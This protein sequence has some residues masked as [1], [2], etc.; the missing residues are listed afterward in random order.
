M[1]AQLLFKAFL[2]ASYDYKINW[3]NLCLYQHNL[4]VVM[5]IN[6]NW[7]TVS[8]FSHLHINTIAA[9]E[10]FEWLHWWHYNLI[11]AG[12]G[13]RANA[14]YFVFLHSYQSYQELHETNNRCWSLLHI[15]PKFG[16][17]ILWRYGIISVFVET[18]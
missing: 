4:T 17:H 1:R 15:I 10:V 9:S 12:L 16:A 13:L 2:V 3:T 14:S 11:K 8:K 7:V 18:D 5:K 6:L